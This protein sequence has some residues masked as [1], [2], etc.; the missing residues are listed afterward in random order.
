MFNWE[1]ISCVEND[2]IK[3]IDEISKD[4]TVA[5]GS[6]VQLE[7]GFAAVD[8]T[9]IDKAYEAAMKKK[10]EIEKEPIE[11]DLRTEVFETAI[12]FSNRIF[13]RFIGGI[14]TKNKVDIK[15]DASNFSNVL[16]YA[17]TVF[18]NNRNYMQ[19]AVI[20]PSMSTS[21]ISGAVLRIY[22]MYTEQKKKIEDTTV[23]PKIK[24]TEDTNATNNAKN[25]IIS[26]IGVI[27]SAIKAIEDV[28]STDKTKSGIFG[29]L[30][31]ITTTVSVK[32][33]TKSVT[34]LADRIKSSLEK[35]QL[36]VAVQ[37]VA[38][39]TMAV[40]KAVTGYAM[41][42]YPEQGQ[43]FIANEAGPELVGTMGGRTA[44]ANSDQITQGITQA[45]APAVYNAVVEA[46]RVSGSNV[47]V[48]LVG[49]TKKIFN[50]VQTEASNYVA[51]TGQSPFM[52]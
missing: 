19:N 10:E 2:K 42:G 14:K 30:N 45:V 20:T 24:A 26:K 29:K 36:Q 17:T 5:T 13:S 9:N 34:S 39:K 18:N 27:N 43:L 47:N 40:F 48:N 4:E 50:V 3:S 8:T 16:G 41:G 38:D 22:E 44:V 35:I 32:E 49:D 28:A 31:E 23:N 21:G 6:V 1:R 37:T 33:D 11:I 51:Q 7:V 46:M 52:V 15:A 12:D 25:S